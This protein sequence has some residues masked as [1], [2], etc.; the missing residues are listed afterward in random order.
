MPAKANYFKLG[1]FILAAIAITVA[2]VLALGAGRL[3]QR[4]VALE[5]YI[6]DSVQGLDIGSKVR[7]RGVLLGEV[8]R[9]GFTAEQY[10]LDKPLG[11]RKPY[12]LVEA[13]LNLSRLGPLGDAD[14][15]LMKQYINQGLRIRVA[16]Q[17]ITGINYLE[18]DFVDPLVNPPLPIDWQPLKPYIPSARAKLVQFTNQIETVLRAL[19]EVNFKRLAGNLDSLI[20]T[21]T[22]K[23]DALPVEKVG[24]EATSLLAELRETNRKLAGLVGGEETKAAIAEMRAAAARLRQ[25]LANPALD[26]LPNDVVLAAERVRALADSERLHRA[27]ANLD[28]TLARLDQAL[29]GSEHDIAATLVNLRQSSEN[30]RELTEAA[31]RYPAGTLFGAPP[32]PVRGS[33]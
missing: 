32:A 7:Y 30:L 24:A 16:P 12:V 5:T 3:F 23:L 27:I 22:R 29:A 17:G 19:E 10:E 15:E 2:M 1:L 18:L 14:V 6:D 28:S 8:K 33:P 13:V 25:V 11:Q 4:T 31:R 21:A 26:T 20:V 9:L